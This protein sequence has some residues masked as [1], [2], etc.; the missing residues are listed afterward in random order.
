M[1]AS[2]QPAGV[3]TSRQRILD[4]ALAEFAARGF[5][6]ARLQDIAGAAG[7]AHPTLLYHFESKEGLYA[8]VV[9]AAT[10]DWA[11]ETRRAISV[12]LQGFDQI[13][14]LIDAAFHFFE[15]HGDFVRLVRREAIEGGERLGAA[16]GDVL[17]PFIAEGVGFLERETAAGRLRPHDPREL[18]A[19][20]YAAVFTHFSDAAL[21]AR[22][23][24]D[25][26]L[27]PAGL[28]RGRDALVGMLRAALAP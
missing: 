26:A 14:S 20:C 19:L 23:L 5:A 16:S 17:G 9:Q 12:N 10:A 7:L 18:I 1:S 25:D 28:R 27:S 8:A 2:T 22:V 3:V 13:A 4:V 11:A 24:G 15:T 6:G 21:R